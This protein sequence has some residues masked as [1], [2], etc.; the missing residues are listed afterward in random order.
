MKHL[1]LLISLSALGCSIL[2]AATPQKV[3]PLFWPDS[4]LLP[5]QVTER[6][7]M[8]DGIEFS[9][10]EFN[11]SELPLFSTSLKGWKQVG[12]LS[13]RNASAAFENKLIAELKT[14]MSLIRAK[15]WLGELNRETLL[16]YTI[17]IQNLH[18]GRV[19][20]L[21]A[22]TG[23]A[24]IGGSGFFAGKPY[25][26]VHYQIASESDPKKVIEVRDFI[27]QVDDLLIIMSFENP[28]GTADRHSGMALNMLDSI[29]RL[30]E[31]E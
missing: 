3:K 7:A 5:V 11:N 22:D 9:I 17:G 14:G 6:L 15:D 8:A 1:I 29:T 25:K 23:F 12:R 26:L 19:T 21:N 24:P 30:D 16:Q 2:S 4:R 10:T 27:T 31:L 18:P 13:H 20:V 28:K